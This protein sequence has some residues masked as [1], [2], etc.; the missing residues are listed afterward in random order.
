MIE[1][2]K[3][4][5]CKVFNYAEDKR[6]GI[7]RRRLISILYR[8]VKVER[9]FAAEGGCSKYGRV[10]IFSLLGVCYKRWGVLTPL[11]VDNSLRLKQYTY[12]VPMLH[13]NA[14]DRVEKGRH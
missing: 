5:R 7:V 8:N 10:W 13:A 11:S 1:V 14:T 3:T 12:E 6:S 4:S 2:V 9:R